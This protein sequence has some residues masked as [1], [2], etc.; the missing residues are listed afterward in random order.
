MA[1]AGEAHALRVRAEVERD[2]VTGEMSD[3]R[4]EHQR[5]VGALWGEKKRSALIT[6]PSSGQY[7]LSTAG[8]LR[9]CAGC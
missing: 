6:G 1:D 9:T 7:W 8:H 3:L 5:E 2:R 4:A